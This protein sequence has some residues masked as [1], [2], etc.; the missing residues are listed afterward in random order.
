MFI[1]IQ[2]RQ[3]IGETE[4]TVVD[5]LNS[6]PV[7][8]Q[9]ELTNDGINSLNYRFQEYVGG[10]WADMDDS[11]TDLYNTLVAGDSL[12]VNIESSYGRVRIV[13]NASGGTVADFTISR[14][15]SRSS[16]GS[17]PILSL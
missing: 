5:I 11:G 6:G 8:A 9:V 1:F 16:G 10:V 12:S 15:Y 14:T 17:L 4:A 3:D 13:G 2:D 7:T